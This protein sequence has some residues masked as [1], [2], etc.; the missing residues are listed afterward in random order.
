MVLLGNLP[1]VMEARDA[2]IRRRR[3]FVTLGGAVSADVKAVLRT[4]EDSGNWTM[5]EQEPTR[6][7]TPKKDEGQAGVF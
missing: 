5:M 4:F 1:R 6:K 7:T 3:D 2:F